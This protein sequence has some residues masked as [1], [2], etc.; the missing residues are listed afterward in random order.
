M[1]TCI[2]RWCHLK[3]IMLEAK[4]FSAFLKGS[5]ESRKIKEK[6]FQFILVTRIRNLVFSLMKFARL[7]LGKDLHEKGEVHTG[8]MWHDHLNIY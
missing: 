8:N 7:Y 5:G 3:K 4:T 2:P 1:A 6:V